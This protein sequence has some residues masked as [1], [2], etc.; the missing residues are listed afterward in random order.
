MRSEAKDPT[1]GRDVAI[2]VMPEEFTVDPDRIAR[3]QRETR[4]LASLKH[5]NIAAIH[6]LEE[7]NG[8]NLLITEL[9]EGETLADRLKR[10]PITVEESLELA[11]QIAEALA[12]TAERSERT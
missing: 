11:L 4:T 7:S 8:T 5:P 3:F 10:G 12:A 9:V 2:K 6:G 1:L